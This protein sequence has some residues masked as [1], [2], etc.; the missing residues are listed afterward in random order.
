M[1][2]NQ[3][4][5]VFDLNL[6]N[7]SHTDGWS[8]CSVQDFTSYF[9]RYG[10]NS[11]CLAPIQNNG[12]NDGGNDGGNNGGNDGGND[13]GKEE[14]QCSNLKLRT[15]SWGK[16]ISW[17]FGACQSPPGFGENING[18]YANNKEY[19]IQ[20]CQPAGTYELDCK[21]KYG[22]GWHGGSIEIGGTEYCKDFRSGRSKK[23][24]VQ[25]SGATTTN[26]CVNLKLKTR[27]W[28]KEISWKFGSCQSPPG[29]G[30]NINGKY[31]N[32]KEYTIQCCQPAG[33]YELDCKDKWGD[34]WH[35]GSIQIG[36]TEYCKDFTKGKS[37]KQQVQ[38]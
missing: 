1:Q 37:K 7:R 29:Y 22:D 30:E 21:D 24:Q 35:G 25:H 2:I 16:E 6:P 32:N 31:A 38:H 10:A 15:K 27:S 19:D 23:Q 34:G 13:G 17:K 20:C 14:N 4:K 5:H 18:K 26:K 33:T 12:G 8:Q 11:Y 28:G 3:L 9:N 36:G